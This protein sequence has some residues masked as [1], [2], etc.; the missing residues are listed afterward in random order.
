MDLRDSNLKLIKIKDKQFFEAESRIAKRTII[1]GLV[2]VLLISVLSGCLQELVKSPDPDEQDAQIFIGE[3]DSIMED[4]KNISELAI[5]PLDRDI[6]A[7]LE[8]AT[9]AMG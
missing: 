2:L 3:E 7:N 9:L 6:P 4:K 8:T 5:P 1:T